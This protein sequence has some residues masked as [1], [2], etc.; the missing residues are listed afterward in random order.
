[1]GGEQN[2]SEEFVE[3]VVRADPC[4]LNCVAGPFADSAMS[5]LTL[6]DQ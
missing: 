5:R 6:I 1:M 2:S 3:L 4:P